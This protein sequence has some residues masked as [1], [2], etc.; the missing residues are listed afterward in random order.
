MFSGP[1]KKEIW[2]T[3]KEQ[4][5]VFEIEY[6]C[7]NPRLFTQSHDEISFELC[8]IISYHSQGVEFGMPTICNFDR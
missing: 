6:A 3:G 1:C 4:K 7:N 8:K 2:R 5:T